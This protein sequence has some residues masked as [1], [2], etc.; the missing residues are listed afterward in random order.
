MRCYYGVREQGSEAAELTLTG[1][2]REWKGGMTDLD[3]GIERG[4]PSS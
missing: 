2:E 3:A 4:L 1:K